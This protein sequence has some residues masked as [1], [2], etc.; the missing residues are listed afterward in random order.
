MLEYK[1]IEQKK[2]SAFKGRLTGDKLAEILNEHASEGWEFDRALGGE[3][4]FLGRD[5]FMM[6]FSREKA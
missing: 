1:V 3:S 5:M 2:K 4:L 6:V